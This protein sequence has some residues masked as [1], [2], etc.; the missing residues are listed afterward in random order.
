MPTIQLT[1]QFR[2][3]RRKFT[4]G[5]N[6]REEQL[7][8]AFSYFADNPKHPSLHMEKLSGS[9]VWT[10]RIDRENRL[11]FIWSDTGD[12]TIFFHVGSHDAYRTFKK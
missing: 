6:Q 3:A 9:A 8:Q 11:F 2:Q 10:I 12:A 5:N 4:K 1:K 7:K